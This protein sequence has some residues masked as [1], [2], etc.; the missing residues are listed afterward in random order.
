[1]RILIALCV[2]LMPVSA[3][4]NDEGLYDPLPPA[5]S[6][7]VRTM[8][9][10][11]LKAYRPQAADETF[12]EG[13]FYT[14]VETPT[15]DK[16]LKDP[17]VEDRSKAVLVFYNVSDRPELSLKTVDGD[18][19]IENVGIGAHGWR[20]VNGVKIAFAIYDGDTKLKDIPAQA[21]QR[22]QAY[23]VMALGDGTDANFLKSET[24]PR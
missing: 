4:A 12:E 15:G 22:G 16:I 6:A 7:F 10:R 11:W 18:V 2:L 3:A 13:E 19:V 1:M 21:L 24:L 17:K 5:G 23:T 8:S 20:A 9:D 14:V